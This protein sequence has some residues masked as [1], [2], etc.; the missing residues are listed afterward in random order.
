[1]MMMVMGNDDDDDD[2]DCVVLSRCKSLRYDV[3]SSTAVDY[4]V[5]CIC[6]IRENLA[7]FNSIHMHTYNI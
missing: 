5:E 4:L 1:M 3:S 2:D 7:S 6:T